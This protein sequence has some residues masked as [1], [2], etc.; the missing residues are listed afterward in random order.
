MM[1]RRHRQVVVLTQGLELTPPTRVPLAV[2]PLKTG[3]CLRLSRAIQATLQTEEIRLALIK[4]TAVQRPQVIKIT[5]TLLTAQFGEG[6]RFHLRKRGTP[7]GHGRDAGAQAE[8]QTQ[9]QGPRPRLKQA[10][11]G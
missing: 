2:L 6:L 8:R 7:L 9:L 1:A 3:R 11:T 10:Q 4:T 5:M